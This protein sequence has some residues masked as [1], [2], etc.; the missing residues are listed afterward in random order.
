MCAS[1][2]H[3]TAVISCGPHI[4]K[5]WVM[6]ETTRCI[7]P[8][9]SVSPEGHCFFRYTLV[10]YSGILNMCSE[11]TGEPGLHILTTGPHPLTSVCVCARACFDKSVFRS[12]NSRV[13]YICAPKSTSISLWDCGWAVA[14]RWEL[15]LYA[16]ISLCHS[17]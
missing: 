14:E 6:I 9:L 15:C 10:T 17:R 3:F 8:T 13:F 12:Q 7:E 4:S 11:A 5:G 1:L 2:D 16:H